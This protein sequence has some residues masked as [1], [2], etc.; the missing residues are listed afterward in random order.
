MAV[1]DA[2]RYRLGTG[3]S[4]NDLYAT[5]RDFLA[6]SPDA[7]TTQA[8]MAQ[9]GISGEDVANA[10]GGASGALQPNQ[11]TLIGDTYYQPIYTQIGSGEDAQLGPLENVL[12]YKASDNQAGGSYNQYTPTGELERTGVQQEVAGSF[13]GGLAEAFNDPV[14]QAAFLGLGGGGFLG[15]QLGLTGS[16]A[17]AVGTGLFKGG[18]AAAGGASFEDALKTGSTSVETGVLEA[19]KSAF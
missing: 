10:T 1:S 4:A 17:Q 12:T 6:A 8:Q 2:M 18:A 13:L 5:I 15:S 16:T 3:G 14:V 9:Y 11:A 7:A 19:A